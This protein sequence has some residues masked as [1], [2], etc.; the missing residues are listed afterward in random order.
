MTN[1]YSIPFSS[2]ID[3]RD[4]Y[5]AIKKG[6]V[7]EARISKVLIQGPAR[8]GKT[9]VKCLILS[10]VYDKSNSTGIAER[11][12]IAFQQF[13]RN[14]EMKWELVNND[15][16]VEMF[17]NEIEDIM[18]ND[19]IE[20]INKLKAYEDKEGRRDKQDVSHNENNERQNRGLED[21]LGQKAEPIL[22]D[23]NKDD[24]SRKTQ[25]KYP[26]HGKVNLHVPTTTTSTRTVSMP[27]MPEISLT[28]TQSKDPRKKL[29]E[30]LNKASGRTKKLKM[31]KEWLY[32]IDAG[33]QIQFQQILQA[34]IPC[35]S[36]LMLVVSLKEKLSS[37]SCTEFQDE[38]G[39]VIVSEHSISIKTL[40]RRLISMVSFNN[41][42]DDVTS[43]DIHL[44]GALTLPKKLKVIAVATHEDKE[45]TETIKEKETQLAEI[46][47]STK[48]NIHYEN[49][50]CENILF[51]VD[52]RKASKKNVEDEAI[53]KIRAE[54]N[55]QAF[56]VTIPLTWYAFEIL[57]R[58][59]ASQATVKSTSHYT[60]GSC[61]GILTLKEC[62][63]VGAV[64]E[65]NEDEIK[66]ALKFFYLL[67]S[68][69]Y[70]PPEVTD[71]VFIDPYSL[72]QV[73][74]ELTI[75]VCK[76]RRGDN[77]GSG[78]YALQ[79]MAKF[80][81][82]SNEV[83]SN[84]K[85][86]MFTEISSKFNGFE[87]HLFKIFI[88]LSLASKL[89][90][91]HIL[92]DTI[93]MPALL[94]LT[95]PLK[96]VPCS[97]YNKTPLLFYFENGTPVGFFCAMIVNL[98]SKESKKDDCNGFM[99]E[100]HEKS[101][102]KFYSNF[103]V[104]RDD[105]SACTLALVESFDWFEIHCKHCEDLPKVKED[106]EIAIADAARKQK[107]R[108]HQT[109]IEKEVKFEIAFYSPCG[110]ETE[111]GHFHIAVVKKGSKLLCNQCDK[112]FHDS[113]GSPR[114]SWIT[115][116]TGM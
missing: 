18:N 74:N 88:H 85:L 5:E 60:A 31:C 86:K 39:T 12:Q 45:R 3:H 115:C 66:R 62:I 65:L 23:F 108:L 84:D 59:E 71:L 36:V 22:S 33:G 57:L 6:G 4:L 47:K 56:K 106:I 14:K 113:K 87:S 15:N 8:V 32:F 67:N 16:I 110:K 46:F 76:V 54:L 42:Q 101:T 78:P 75:L 1:N 105:K 112:F 99:W 50:S 100:I 111:D 25:E 82:I 103:V 97:F 114:L 73:V 38:D 24:N 79:Q 94:P 9:S 91:H 11:P 44:S 28:N 81:I 40:L 7:V 17:A 27:L 72:I 35:A 96:G 69:L 20:K 98:L 34:F 58:D 21:T 104:L 29:A 95:D 89:P 109:M 41:Q 43:S 49:P 102:D 64:L 107:Q 19:K 83:L 48:H 26:Q 63:D 70:Y 51:K 68:I 77:V 93:F 37:Q 92:H 55:E 52:G 90:H 30:T 2:V 10:Q 80:G 53:T 61:C 13:G 116:I